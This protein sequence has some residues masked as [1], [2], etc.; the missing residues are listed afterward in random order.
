MSWTVL[1]VPLALAAMAVLALIFLYLYQHG[2][3]KYLAFWALGFAVTILRYGM[4]LVR[5]EATLVLLLNQLGELLAAAFF[6]WGTHQFVG[7]EVPRWWFFG[8]AGGA[9]WIVAGIALR[10][11]FFWLSLPT[12]LFSGLNLL[13]G[14]VAFLRWGSGDG[15]GPKLVG[16]AFI[17]WGLHRLDYPLVRPVPSLA[18]WG[19]LLS[20]AL[21]MVVAIGMLLASFEKTRAALESSNER[22][23]RIFAFS[24]CPM[25][26]ASLPG[27]T[28][29]DAN[30]AYLK[31]I[32]YERAQ[33]VGRT[34]AELGLWVNERERAHVMQAVDG[35]LPLH[36]LEA[37]FR[38]RSG[39]MRTGLFSLERIDLDGVAHLLITVEDVTERHSAEREIRYLSFHDKLTGL[40]NRAFFEAEAG[41]LMCEPVRPFSLI[42][43]DVNGLKLVNDAFGHQHGDRLLQ[44]IARVFNE[45]C[46]PADIVARWGG[47][48]FAILLPHTPY[49]AAAAVCDRITAACKGT[50]LGP[51]PLSVSLGVATATEL[52]GELSRLLRNAEDEM[53]RRKLLESRSTQ[54]AIIASLGKALWENSHE[55]VEHG[56]RLR[57][58]AG[59]FGAALNIGP[60]Q[61]DE[62]SLLAALHDIGKVAIPSSVLEKPGPLT[63]EE[64]AIIKRHPEIGYRIAQAAP[65]LA[66]MADAILAHHERWD[67]TGYPRGLRGQE[68]PLVARILAIVDAFDVM[69]HERPYKPANGP[70]RAC[71]EL[72]RCAGTQFDPE[73]V[74]VFLRTFAASAGSGEAAG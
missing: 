60:A 66:G 35:A 69:T 47:D 28:C 1:S 15:L 52:G 70:E 20:A 10:V 30:E 50:M 37:D 68:I 43:G 55:T 40:Y 25:L 58:M 57:Q 12:F 27:K 6:F 33:V 74:R 8:V 34:T 16:W 73:L 56:E 71:A 49:E 38:T 13:S 39:A 36:G 14:G 26:I 32:G 63:S 24:P 72:E 44:N 53:Y 17:L 19:F 42:L 29:V 54:S 31:A 62:L 7:R 3:E 9:A 46:R 61:R 67:G 2:R 21:E 11:S 23:R 22:L 59:E 5:P 4:E 51:V 64:W 41:R 65:N 48:E 45:A 18:P